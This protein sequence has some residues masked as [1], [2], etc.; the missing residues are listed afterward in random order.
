MDKG[1]GLWVGMSACSSL[2]TNFMSDAATVAL[3]GPVKSQS[4][5]SKLN[6]EVC[7]LGIV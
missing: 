2:V 6:D 5:F 1:Y 3:I 7:K 4:Y